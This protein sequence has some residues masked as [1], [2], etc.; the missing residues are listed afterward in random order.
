MFEKSLVQPLFDG[1]I[2]IVGDVHG[3]IDELHDLLFRL[4]YDQSGFHP[5][6]RRLVFLGDLIDRGPD[7]PAVVRL[8]RQ[9]VAAGRAQCVLG[10]HD[11]NVLRNKKNPESD[12]FFQPAASRAEASASE[13]PADGETKRTILE[14]FGSLPLVLEGG[15][16]RVVHACWD[17]RM[18]ELSRA[19]ASVMHLYEEHRRRIK[20]ELDGSVVDRIDRKLAYQNGN[21]VKL[22][23]SGPEERTLEPFEAG[24]KTRY[25]RRVPWWESYVDEQLCVFG[26]YSNRRGEPHGRGRAIC[27]DYGISY[28]RSKQSDGAFL[29]AVRF[30]ERTVMFDNGQHEE[31]KL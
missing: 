18:V 7:S 20:A 13:V 27:V 5:E 3:Y 1:P 8:V 23:T 21:P 14:L 29:A 24:G 26:H 10:N 30:Q 9:L 12:W 2:D 6:G 17:D 22:L 15:G 31:L 16:L 4:G 11:F 25:E 19:A 28:R